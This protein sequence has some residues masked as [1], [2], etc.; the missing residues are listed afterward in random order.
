M[1]ARTG[2]L[3]GLGTN[4]QMKVSSTF[5][6]IGEIVKIEGPDAV[7]G[8]RET[9]VLSS[10]A[11]AYR[12]TLPDYGKAKFTVHWDPDDSLHL[13]LLTKITSP[14]STPDEFKLIFV[15]GDTTPANVDF[16][17][18]LMSFKLKGMEEKGTLEA[19][20]EIQITDV[21][22]PTAGTA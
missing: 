12:P 17:G 22:T 18:F 19:D 8:L 21:F 4:L 14:V 10:S 6:S 5:T 20:L 9:T 15:D 13:S 11:K 2:G 1:A 7:L 16:K 3:P